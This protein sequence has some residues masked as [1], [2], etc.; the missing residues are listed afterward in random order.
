M[1]L[2]VVLGLAFALVANAHTINVSGVFFCEND[3]RLPVFVELMEEDPFKDDR[4]HWLQTKVLEN[5]EIKGSEDEYRFITPYLRV[6]HNCRGTEEVITINF[7]RREGEVTI[8]IG[9]VYLDDPATK[10]DIRN[11]FRA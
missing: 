5:F 11:K 7:G 9:D 3:H 4:L 8:D 1:F 6:F 10:K 2:S